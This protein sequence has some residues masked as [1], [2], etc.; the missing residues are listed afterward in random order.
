MQD[1]QSAWVVA[2][3]LCCS[4]QYQL[5]SVYLGAVDWYVRF[6]ENIW[7]CLGRILLD[8][9]MCSDEIRQT[10]TL[11]LILG[12]IGLRSADRLRVPAFWE[13]WA[14]CLLTWQVNSIAQLEGRLDTPILR[15]EWSQGFRST[16][17]ESARR[18]CQ[19]TDP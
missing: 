12:G 3:P 16:I 10:A 4:R 2:P 19:A 5:R 7:L 18:R 13:S 8:L 1:V 15:A 9:G 17:L 11:P 6:H 14:D